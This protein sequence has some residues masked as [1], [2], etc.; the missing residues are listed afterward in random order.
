MAESGKDPVAGTNQYDNG[1]AWEDYD[2]QVGMFERPVLA[3][4]FNQAPVGMWYRHVL[5]L[6]KF[7]KFAGKTYQ[8]VVADGIHQFRIQ[9]INQ[10]TTRGKIDVKFDNVRIIYIPK[11]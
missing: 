10:S 2:T 4:F 1:F 7:G 11:K 9:S 8:D 3:D 5:P 6:S